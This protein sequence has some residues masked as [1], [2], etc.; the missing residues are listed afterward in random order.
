VR[1]S[2]LRCLSARALTIDR[3]GRYAGLVTC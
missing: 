1:R 3:F 2:G